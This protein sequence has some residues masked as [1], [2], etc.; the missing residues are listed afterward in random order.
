M[1][2]PRKIIDS[3]SISQ[4]YASQLLAVISMLVVATGLVLHERSA[5]RIHTYDRQSGSCYSPVSINPAIVQVHSLLS[6]AQL[7]YS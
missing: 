2:R 4:P 1:G 6:F 3:S 5:D 7:S